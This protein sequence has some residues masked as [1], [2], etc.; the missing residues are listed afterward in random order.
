MSSTAAFDEVKVCIDLISAVEGD[1]NDFVLV[2]GGKRDTMLYRKQHR[3]MGRGNARY[4]KPL[5]NDTP[6]QMGDRARRCGPGPEP[7]NHS[8]FDHFRD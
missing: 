7:Y 6:P 3:L 2:Q 8:V 4:G 5:V 1:I